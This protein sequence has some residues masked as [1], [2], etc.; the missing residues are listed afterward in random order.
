MAR[1]RPPRILVL[2]VAVVGSA[3]RASD[4]VIVDDWGPPAGYA[5]LTGTVRRT[6][7]ALA[8]GVEVMFTR[9]ASPVGGYLTGATTDAAGHFR[10]TG[11]LP[12]RG[13]L[14]PGIADTLRLRCDVFLDR[15]GVVRDSVTVRFAATTQSS[16]VIT[17]DLVAP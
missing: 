15:A 14:P 6:S 1:V 5:V 13:V 12:P 9:C 10:A 17:I 8:A 16:P 2:A 11:Q 3:C 4:T 7:G